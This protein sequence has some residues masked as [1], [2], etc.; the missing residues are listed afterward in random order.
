MGYNTRKSSAKGTNADD[1]SDHH[2]GEHHQNGLETEEKDAESINSV[3]TVE[4]QD[5]MDQEWVPNYPTE[6]GSDG[7]DPADNTGQRY[8][9]VPGQMFVPIQAAKGRILYH[10]PEQPKH[11][12][13]GLAAPAGESVRWAYVDLIDMTVIMGNHPRA[14]EI[15]QNVDQKIPFDANRQKAIYTTTPQELLEAAGENITDKRYWPLVNKILAVLETDDDGQPSWDEVAMDDVSKLEITGDSNQAG[16][17]K[18]IA[19]VGKEPTAPRTD[20]TDMRR[21][22]IIVEA[23]LQVKVRAQVALAD[24]TATTSHHMLLSC[25]RFQDSANQGRSS[26]PIDKNR[27]YFRVAPETEVKCLSDQ[28]SAIPPATTTTTTTQKPASKDQVPLNNNVPKQQNTLP[29]NETPWPDGVVR[30][31]VGNDGPIAY[32][33]Q[34]TFREDGNVLA[35]RSQ[36]HTVPQTYMSQVPA[37]YRD[38]K[39]ETSCKTGNYEH[40]TNIRPQEKHV[41][42]DDN[43]MINSVQSENRYIQSRSRDDNEGITNAYN[44]QERINSEQSSR[45]P[46]SRPSREMKREDHRGTYAS[47]GPPYKYVEHDVRDA[48]DRYHENVPNSNSNY[49]NN[50]NKTSEIKGVLR[51]GDENPQRHQNNRNE[52]TYRERYGDNWN[53]S[54]SPH[55]SKKDRSHSP[56]LRHEDRRDRSESPGPRDSGRR[57]QSRSPVNDPRN[58]RPEYDRSRSRSSSEKRSRYKQSENDWSRSRSP[59]GDRSRYYKSEYDRSPR[60]QSPYSDRNDRSFDDV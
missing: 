51:N 46:V 56:P 33:Q 10:R 5:D 18:G 34:P 31:G 44:Y 17:A 35:A 19:E 6:Q 54:Q 38:L 23:G 37:E 49:N 60:R 36:Q 30:M 9:V 59:R 40:S 47:N 25:T 8:L 2:E 20:L 55:Y 50:N 27:P 32:E 12:K 7:T 22:R 43:P 14:V 52:P 53:R 45:E 3:S 48:R 15:E 13:R 58:Y 39:I 24:L 41:T 57:D 42:I 11:E 16:G 4:E 28:T 1:K 26:T 21:F 29:E